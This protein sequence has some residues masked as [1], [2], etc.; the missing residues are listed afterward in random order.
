M[1][2]AASKHTVEKLRFIFIY[3]FIYELCLF[4][5]KTMNKKKICKNAKTIT[6][7]PNLFALIKFQIQHIIKLIAY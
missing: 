3:L 7:M 5:C 1:I 2:N 6:I 4:K